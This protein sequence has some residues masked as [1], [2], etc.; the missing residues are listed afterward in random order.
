MNSQPTDSPRPCTGVASSLSIWIVS[1][2]GGGWTGYFK[3]GLAAKVENGAS[4]HGKF[5]LIDLTTAHAVSFTL[6]VGLR[7]LILAG[8]FAGA[9][10][11]GVGIAENGGVEAW[12]N[13][14][15]LWPITTIIT[16]SCG[17]VFGK[18]QDSAGQ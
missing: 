9:L 1:S 5:S 2:L 7:G 13:H 12:L 15:W 18:A 10:F 8:V 3:T 6:P 17:V 16:F 11:H 14:A 4:T